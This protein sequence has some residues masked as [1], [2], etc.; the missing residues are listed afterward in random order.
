MTEGNPILQHY[1]R[2]IGYIGIWML[3]T[4]VQTG[5]IHLSTRI[6]LWLALTDAALFSLLFA[7]FALMLWY[8]VRFSSWIQQGSRF[9][10]LPY[11]FLAVMVV[12]IWMIAGN[13][14]MQLLTTNPSYLSF[15][16]ISAGWRAI[17]G[18][19]FYVVIVLFYCHQI[20]LSQLTEK[21]EDFKK[22]RAKQ[23]D[24]FT[25]ITV[26]DRQQIH[27]I[28]I[29]EIDYIE[30]Y[31]DYVQ[32]HTVKGVFIKEQTMK[33]FEEHLPPQHFIRIH[34]S[35]FVNVE[36][37]TKIELYEKES[38]RVWLKSG[39]MLKASSSGYKRMKEV[40]HL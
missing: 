16:Q 22:S 36:Q 30:A 24:A 35:Y 38:Y 40:V 27:L 6:P 19:L 20:Q 25:R 9:R 7:C 12:S 17:E 3:M 1:R 31:G 32:L 13:E 11:T 8:P 34:R 29:H 18:A 23:A 21:M 14:M 37:V 5:A 33:F 15:I 2:R 39:A 4:L 10:L 28:S 26:K